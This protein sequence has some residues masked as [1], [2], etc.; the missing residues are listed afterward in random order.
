MIQEQEAANEEL[1]AANEEILS[2]NEEMQSVNE[3]LETASEELNSTNEELESRNEELSRVADD[4]KNLLTS[5]NLP[6]VMVDRDLRVRR[7]TPEAE[8]LFAVTNAAV[9]RPVTQL[10]QLLGIVDLETLLGKV[11]DELMPV[12]RSVLGADGR[13]YAARLRPYMTGDHRV[14]GAVLMLTDVDAL[15]RRYET[16]LGIATVLQESFFHPLP[17]IERVALADFAAA[18]NQPELVGGDF[19]DVF[20]MPEG[21][22]V[23][24]IGDVVGKGVK[25]ARLAETTRSAVRAVALSSGSPAFI[26]SQVSRLLLEEGARGELVTACLLVLDQSTGHATMASAGHPPPV[27]VGHSQCVFVEV[28]PGTPLGAFERPYEETMFTLERGEAL[29]FY[30]DGVT[31]A[32]RN[33]ELFDEPRLLEVLSRGESREPRDLVDRLKQAL[34]RYAGELKDD[35]QILALQWTDRPD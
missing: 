33:G 9:G 22:V 29:V 16:Q 3:E 15:M 23:A 17:L 4:L 31:E 11:V 35:V 8:R 20:Q 18:A 5:V 1:R 13:R 34:L 24:L 19:R 32:R 12:E 21:Q 27:R 7:F 10:A 14:D 26:L 25:A 6:V 28:P 2:S 30:T